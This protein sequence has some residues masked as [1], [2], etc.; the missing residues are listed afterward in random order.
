MKDN[1]N[2]IS[3][4]YIM[5]NNV[6]LNYDGFKRKIYLNDGIQELHI[7][8]KGKEYTFDIEKILKLLCKELEK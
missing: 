2:L 4:D 6:S 3:C 7:Q 1:K 8:Y 5:P